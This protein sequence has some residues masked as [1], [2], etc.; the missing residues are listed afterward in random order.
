MARESQRPAPRLAFA[1]VAVE[2]EA[3]DF[4]AVSWR[5]TNKSG[6]DVLVVE[7]WL[8]HNGFY[9]DK[10]SLSPELRVEPAGSVE[11]SRRVRCRATAEADVENAFLILQVDFVGAV[12]RIFVRMRVKAE[13]SSMRPI[14]EAVTAQTVGLVKE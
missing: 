7:T 10:E 12:W 13:A 3:G 9:A 14:I 5:I 1:V 11:V 2:P 4:F 6:A 8:P